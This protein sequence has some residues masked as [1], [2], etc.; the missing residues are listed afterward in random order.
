MLSI[1]M[2]PYSLLKVT[3]LVV[4][5]WATEEKRDILKVVQIISAVKKKR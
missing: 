4:L 2:R 3:T 5:E 1:K